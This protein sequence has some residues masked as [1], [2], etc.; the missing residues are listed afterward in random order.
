MIS[1]ILFLG[2]STEILFKFVDRDVV[3][4]NFGNTI[5]LGDNADLKQVRF[6]NRLDFVPHQE[7]EKLEKYYESKRIFHKMINA[8]KYLI[9]FRLP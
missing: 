7:P 4:E 2:I 5:E 9:Y 3:L 6:S 8:Q 1:T